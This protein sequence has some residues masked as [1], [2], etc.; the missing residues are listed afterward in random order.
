MRSLIR[1]VML[2]ALAMVFGV[3]RGEGAALTA[4]PFADAKGTSE[5]LAQYHGKVLLVVNTA[6]KCGYT[7]QYADLEKIYA[8]YKD[9]GLVVVAFPSNDFGGQEPGTN[10][11]IQEFCSSKFG[12]TFPVKGKMPVLG[13][14]KSPL[15]AA[16][17]G[18]A[19]PKPGEIKWN[20]EKFL[21]DRDG[22]IVDRWISKVTP[23]DPAITGAIE[24]ALGGEAPKAATK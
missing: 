20:F 19:S 6:S 8:Q 21:I 5:T 11:Q 12:V 1:A 3:V 16:L 13:P 17:T 15:Y 10:L 18:A 7:K 14:Q 2:M 23:S 9:R 4:I 22:K 24:K